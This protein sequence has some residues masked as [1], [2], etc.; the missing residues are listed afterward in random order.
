V[1][2]TGPVFT[3][4][5]GL[6]LLARPVRAIAGTAVP[7]EPGRVR[8]VDPGLLLTEEGAPA[9]RE[10]W[11]APVPLHELALVDGRPWAR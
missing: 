9:V 7:L 6:V 10:L 4:D 8:G 1:H 3:A 11:R 2:L 5:G